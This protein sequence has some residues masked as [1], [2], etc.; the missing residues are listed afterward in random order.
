MPLSQSQE[1]ARKL[2]MTACM[3]NLFHVRQTR[4]EA[5]QGGGDDSAFNGLRVR[6]CATA[7]IPSPPSECAWMGPY[8]P[9]PLAWNISLTAQAVS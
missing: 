6:C 7:D 3:A 9:E 4:I 5:S 1:Q 8:V 2:P